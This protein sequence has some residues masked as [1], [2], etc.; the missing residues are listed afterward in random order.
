MHELWGSGLTGHRGK[1]SGSVVTRSKEGN[2]VCR[3]HR[4]GKDSEQFT[5]DCRFLI[6]IGN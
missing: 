1:A 2:H 4:E 6:I 5:N 3:E